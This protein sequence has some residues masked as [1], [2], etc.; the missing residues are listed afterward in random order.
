MR[1]GAAAL[2]AVTLGRGNP[3]G[4]A[5]PASRLPGA[6]SAPNHDQPASPAVNPRQREM[7]SGHARIT[8][9][10]HYPRRTAFTRRPHSVT[11]ASTT[12]PASSPES[13]PAVLRSAQ[14]HD[15][16]LAA[17]PQPFGVLPDLHEPAVLEN[18]AR[19]PADR[20]RDVAPRHGVG[21]DE[22]DVPLHGR[23]ITRLRER[24]FERRRELEPVEAEFGG[25]HRARRARTARALPANSPTT[26]IRSGGR[27]PGRSSTISAA[28]AAGEQVEIDRPAV[29]PRPRSPAS[30]SPVEH[31]LGEPLRPRR[32][33]PPTTSAASERLLDGRVRRSPAAGAGDVGPGD[34]EE[35][36]IARRPTATLPARASSRLGRRLRRRRSAPR[37]SAGAITS[38]ARIAPRAG[39]RRELRR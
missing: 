16:A 6:W 29:E 11:T 8:C 15:E 10:A 7:E 34:F 5:P 30:P 3:W 26:A 33:S 1:A 14:R 18:V 35:V 27:E 17:G 37:T 38:G 12:R 24:P 23:K 20:R 22:V 9:D 2:G 36:G 19:R 4:F 31:R 25:R 32:S 28:P 13:V 21:D 39:R